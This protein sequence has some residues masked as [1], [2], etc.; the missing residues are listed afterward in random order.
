MIS[1]NYDP[2]ALTFSDSRKDL[3]WKEIE[4]F[5]K[6]IKEE[7]WKITSILDIWCWNGRLVWLLK[8]HWV[9]YIS[10][11]WVDSSEVLLSE[12]KKDYPINRFMHL[13]M[14]SLDK[15][16]EK[17][18]DIFFIAS[19]HHLQTIEERE[20]VLRKAYNLLENNGTIY[21]TNWALESS[22]NYMTYR[23]SQ[24]PNT[25]NEFW[26]SDFE[27]KIWE[28]KR[29]YHSFSLDELTHLFEKVWFKI[30]ENKEFENKKNIISVI[31]KIED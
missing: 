2:F 24:I 17:F 20:E 23:N 31:K 30:I 29:F 25:E 13:D 3:K 7:D 10:Y 9:D 6:Y 5:F 14:M 8:E 22:I 28:H 12:A 4:H 18:S 15:I 11:L 16:E 19:F 21:M 26:S 1:I 27:I